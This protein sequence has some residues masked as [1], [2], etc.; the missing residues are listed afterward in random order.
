MYSCFRGIR[1]MV[2]TVCVCVCVERVYLL[3]YYIIKGQCMCNCVFPLSLCAS[4]YVC[5]LSMYTR[6]TAAFKQQLDTFR[7]TSLISGAS[8]ACSWRCAS[9][10]QEKHMHR[11][12]RQWCVMHRIIAMRPCGPIFSYLLRLQFALYNNWLISSIKYI[13]HFPTNPN[14]RL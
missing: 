12:T 13:Q 10:H 8:P 5:G 3:K 4:T 6:F 9:V 1:F 14:A 11:R 7:C 2:R